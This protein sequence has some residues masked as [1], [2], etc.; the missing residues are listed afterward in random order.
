MKA[1]EKVKKI[2]TSKEKVSYSSGGGTSVPPRKEEVYK[3]NEEESKEVAIDASTQV[4]QI[5]DA[6]SE[7]KE[8]LRKRAQEE[9]DKIKSLRE[10]AE[11]VNH[12]TNVLLGVVVL[13]FLGILIVIITDYAYNW[14]TYRKEI[15]QKLESYQ[16]IDESDKRFS[17]FK[18]CI[19]TYG[20]NFCVNR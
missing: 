3:I 7:Q 13:F 8:E 5:K 12:N 2:K 20:V 6:G 9:F 16:R 14:H 19:K 1:D 15:E 4:K 10:E 18:D 11:R 17:L